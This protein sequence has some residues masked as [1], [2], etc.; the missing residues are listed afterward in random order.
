LKGS[1]YKFD[2]GKLELSCMKKQ[3]LTVITLTVYISVEK[4]ELIPKNNFVTAL[5][6]KS[7][8]FKIN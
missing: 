5:K 6:G 2:V 4:D 8:D 7:F 3:V 1:K